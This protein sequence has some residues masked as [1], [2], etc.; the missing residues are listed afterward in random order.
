[1]AKFTRFL[2]LLGMVLLVGACS[3]DKPG[4]V[5]V[6]GQIQH[7]GRSAIYLSYYIDNHVL[8]YDTIFSNESGNFHFDITG[9]EEIN[10]ITLFFHD[11]NYWTTVFAKSGDVIQIKGDIELV[12]LLTI[13]GG[14][15]ND[16]LTRFKQD[17]HLL[18]VERKNIMNG[19]YQH[20]GESVDVRL[21]EINLGLKRKAKEFIL[22]HP[23][24]FASV[25]L[26]QDFF[27]QDYDPITGELLNL[28]QG[29]AL[30]NHLTERLKQGIK[31]W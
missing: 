8:A 6:D 7:L 5:S 15:V 18:Y 10:P 16:D 28:L 22:E 1:M 11:F 17:I 23:A 20:G 31:A 4:R 12:D 2:Y 29:E 3:P 24:S 13:T 26:I 9:T 25:V 21:A 14:T 30:N 27:Y 19:K